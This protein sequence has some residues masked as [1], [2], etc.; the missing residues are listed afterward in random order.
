MTHQDPASMAFLGPR[1]RTRGLDAQQKVAIRIAS[2]EYVILTPNP[3]ARH[4]GPCSLVS[5]TMIKLLK[6]P[7]KASRRPRH[8]PN[9]VGLAADRSNTPPSHSPA[10]TIRVA[11]P[12]AARRV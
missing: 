5:S 10:P 9:G 7:G 1:R 3:S 4:V 12:A 2:E 6:C 8:L 11:A